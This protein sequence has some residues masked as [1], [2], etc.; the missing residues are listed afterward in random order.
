MTVK[1]TYSWLKQSGTQAEQNTVH[2][3]WISKAFPLRPGTNT[4]P[5]LACGASCRS[6]A[7]RRSGFPFTGRL[8]RAKCSVLECMVP[9]ER[10]TSAAFCL[11][12][13]W[14]VDILQLDAVW[15]THSHQQQKSFTTLSLYCSQLALQSFL[16]SCNHHIL[17]CVTSLKSNHLCL[18]L[19]LSK[20]FIPDKQQTKFQH[21]APALHAHS[22]LYQYVL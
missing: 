19:Y 6:R 11:L 16:L 3:E 13:Q 2:V 15:S 10:N 21:Q 7:T 8:K 18:K 9:S 4:W 22:A 17:V 14:C 5:T 12:H 20:V 1:S